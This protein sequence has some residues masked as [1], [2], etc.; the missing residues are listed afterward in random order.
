MSST[1]S[2]K[3]L[4]LFNDVDEYKQTICS[5][6]IDVI[7]TSN[8]LASENFDQIMTI[9][10]CH[11]KINK[12]SERILNRIYQIKSHIQSSNWDQL[13]L[14]EKIEQLIDI[15]DTLF[16]Q[17]AS[18]LDEADG[19]KISPIS[20]AVRQVLIKPQLNFQY[21]ID[22]STIIPFIPKIR[23]KPN[24]L[25]PLP[26][27]MAQMNFEPIDLD[28]LQKHPEILD[29]PYFDEIRI[30]EPD[31]MLL[32]KI[33]PQFPKS[34]EETKYLFVDTIEKLKTMMDHI[35]IQLELAID[36]EHHSYR[37]YQGF[38]CLMQISSRTEDFLIDTLTL[39]DELSILNNVF[40]NSKV[41]KVIFQI[42]I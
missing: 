36:L 17:I 34:I 1:N 19:I 12:L 30:F 38:T 25:T 28:L 27:M 33:E 10:S 35:E 16:E 4:D 40:T 9:D 23:I 3:F 8:R 29:H 20:T 32:K 18:A 6:V 24:A 39:R 14:D 31:E 42:F 5:K 13:D 2:K 22:N 21:K 41:L 7:R 15:N 37:S 26:M 11:D